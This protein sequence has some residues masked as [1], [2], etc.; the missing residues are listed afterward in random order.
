M[1]PVRTRQSRIEFCGLCGNPDL[2]KRVLL[3]V[4][5]LLIL[6]SVPPAFAAAPPS[7]LAAPYHSAATS[8]QR[9]LVKEVAALRAALRDFPSLLEVLDSRRPAICLSDDLI[10]AR[11]YYE[12][13]T[14]RIV[15][16]SGMGAGLTLAMLVHELRHLY[17]F[18]GDICPSDNLAMK[19]YA[20]GVFAM[21]ADANVVSLMVAWKLRSGGDPRMW[22]ALETWPMTADI[23]VRF[24]ERMTAT[25]NVPAAA[26]AAFDQWY[27]LDIRREKYYVAACSDYLERSDRAHALP[28]YQSLPADFLPR[29]CLLPDGSTYPCIEAEGALER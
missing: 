7:C 1:V 27:A 2:M 4:I 24:A 15:F 20:R 10:E 3:S 8:D 29:L 12:P 14:N 18:S 11:A 16:A 28:S 13:E 25:G 26:A 22:R 19:E 6:G 5:L 21:E 9:R 23:A 17:Q